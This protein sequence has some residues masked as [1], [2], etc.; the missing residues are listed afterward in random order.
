MVSKISSNQNPQYKEWKKLHLR[1]YRDSSKLFLI[2]GIKSLY[3]AIVWKSKFQAI[4]YS[5]KLF[6]SNGGME[7]LEHITNHGL[8]LY[9]L[10]NKLL[11]ELSDLENSQGIIGIVEQPD[12]NIENLIVYEKSSIIILDGIQDPGNMGTI[13]RTADAAGI[14]GVLLGKGCVDIYNLKVI[15]STMGSI[16]HLPIIQ[17]LNI[18]D[19]IIKLIKNGFQIIG[20]DLNSNCYYNELTYS[21]KKAVIVGSE[22]NGISEPILNLCSDLVKIPIKGHAQSLNAAVAAGIL[23]YKMVGI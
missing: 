13:I 9:E 14:D 18:N 19:T 6:S 1:K 10:D 8:P 17:E 16:F 3:E 22:S 21:K 15:R 11:L 23:M 12:Y 5:N 2:E 4:L 20:T 7:L